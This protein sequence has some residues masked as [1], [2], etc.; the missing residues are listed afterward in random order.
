MTGTKDENWFDILSVAVELAAGAALQ[1]LIDAIHA[2]R[3]DNIRVVIEK[4]H[5]AHGQLEKLS[6][7]LRT[8]CSSLD[9]CFHSFY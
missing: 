4:L 5:I 1:P 9:I 6:K 2:V 8:F 7:I 3:Q